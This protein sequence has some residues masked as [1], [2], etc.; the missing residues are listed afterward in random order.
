MNKRFIFILL[1]CMFSFLSA[2]AYAQEITIKGVVLDET[3]LGLPGANIIVKGGKVGTATDLD[4]NFSLTVPSSN[5]VIVVS[6]IGSL[7]ST[8]KS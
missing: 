6:Y 4:G 1:G 8:K 3:E 2:T 7:V 5:S